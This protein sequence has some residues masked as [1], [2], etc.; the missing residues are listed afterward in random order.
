MFVG[1]VFETAG[2]ECVVTYTHTHMHTNTRVHIVLDTMGKTKQLSDIK[3]Q[4][5][6]NFL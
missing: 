4:I 5:K 1:R 6:N 2:L 3:L